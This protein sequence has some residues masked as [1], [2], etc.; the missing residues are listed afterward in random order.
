MNWKRKAHTLQ[1]PNANLK[2]LKGQIY[3]QFDG[4]GLVTSEEYDFKGNLLKKRQQIL[5]NYKTSVDWNAVP[6]PEFTDDLLFRTSNKFDALNR[7]KEFSNPDGSIYAAFFNKANLLEKIDVYIRGA[8]IPTHFVLNINYNA[9]G[10]RQKVEYG[11]GVITRY[12]YDPATF[13]LISLHTYK[14][15][16]D[17]QKYQYT[18]DP[19]GNITSLEDLASQTIFF[20]NAVVSPKRE[21]RYDPLYRLIEACGREHAGQVPNNDYE[22]IPNIN[23]I[24]HPNN[25]NALRKYTEYYY[26]D[27]AGN[28]S[29]VKHYANSNNW[30][31]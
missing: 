27:R 3:Q 25:P 5:K 23:N 18:Y 28:I 21:Y 14:N 9:K 26:Y 1:L 13:R 7:L 31:K 2:N 16:K 11:N 12:R 29:Q 17:F 10:Q 15:G 4:A 24:P 22:D 6:I 8:T 30:V 20:N 19:I